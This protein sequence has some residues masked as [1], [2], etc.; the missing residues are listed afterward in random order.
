MAT[1]RVVTFSVMPLALAGAASARR[2]CWSPYPSVSFPSPS[3]QPSVL[4]RVARGEPGAAEECVRRYGDLV[5]SVARRLSGG[6]LRA[7][8]DDAVQEIFVDLWRSAGRFDPTVA[9]EAAFVVMIARRRL[10]DRIRRATRR[11]PGVQLA[12]GA[13]QHVPARATGP[14]DAERLAGAEDAAIALRAIDSLSPEQQRCIRLAVQHGY[15]HT[16]VAEITGLPL[17]TVKTHVRRGL[18]RVREAIESKTAAPLGAGGL[19]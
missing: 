5:W 16:Q 2:P 18:L 8:A 7:D 9:S 4:D 14:T 11:P 17:G 6:A 15:T 19:R 12:E 10:I 13:E 1:L 3:N